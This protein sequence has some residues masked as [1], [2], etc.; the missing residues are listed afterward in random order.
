MKK[1]PNTQITLKHG[2]GNLRPAGRMR[3]AKAFFPARDLLLS[4]GPGPFFNDRY[5]AI[6][7]RNDSHHIFGSSPHQFDR[8]KTSFFLVFAI[9]D[10][11]KRPEFLSKTFLFRSAEMVA[12]RWNLVRT[13][14]GPLV[15]KVADPL[16]L[17]VQFN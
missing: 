12:A 16:N 14:C 4:S 13:E 2:V 1:K 15:R 6:Y 3:P 11:E 7:R 9:N 10:A 17:K 5:A 8:A